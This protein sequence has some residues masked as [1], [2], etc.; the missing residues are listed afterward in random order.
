M[1]TSCMQIQRCESH[2]DKNLKGVF[3]GPVPLIRHLILVHI[4]L[5]LYSMHDFMLEYTWLFRDTAM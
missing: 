4:V 3:E 5:L 1:R 2:V